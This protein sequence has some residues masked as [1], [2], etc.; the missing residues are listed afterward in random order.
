MH[1]KMGSQTVG[2][3]CALEIEFDSCCFKQNNSCAV[4]VQE[5]IYCV[6]KW[7]ELQLS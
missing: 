6:K 7:E 4:C 2:E 3:Q 5:M 1:L